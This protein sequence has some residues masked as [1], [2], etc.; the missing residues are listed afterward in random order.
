M[1]TLRKRDNLIHHPG[2][3][4]GVW[5]LL[6][7]V[8]SCSTSFTIHT[9]WMG[10]CGDLCRTTS[11][12]G[13]GW[14]EGVPVSAAHVSVADLS[15]KESDPSSFILHLSSLSFHFPLCPRSYHI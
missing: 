14:G 3:L 12:P 8:A 1:A 11:P 6:V 5:F 15:V 2:K 10:L 7:F 9:R 4:D 13:A